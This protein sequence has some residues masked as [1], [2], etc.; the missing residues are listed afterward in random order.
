MDL[1]N[2]TEPNVFNTVI[3]SPKNE[4]EVKKKL[5]TILSNLVKQKS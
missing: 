2:A 1:R 3:C 5:K 4:Q